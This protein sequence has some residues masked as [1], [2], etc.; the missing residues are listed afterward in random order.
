MTNTNY[1]D[2]YVDHMWRFYIRNQT[3]TLDT[4]GNASRENWTVCDSIYHK[5]SPF[6]QEVL[7]AYYAPYSTGTAQDNLTVYC[8]EHNVTT[9]QANNAIRSIRT[10]TAVERGL[11]D[12]LPPEQRKA[13]RHAPGSGKRTVVAS[14]GLIEMTGKTELT[15]KDDPTG[16]N[17]DHSEQSNQ[18]SEPT[19]N[20][21]E[22]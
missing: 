3:A 4:L 10:I 11:L 12:R 13:F 9:E 1:Y 22:E 2:G 20:H 14:S 21:A 15:G 18:H 17:A 8:E 5:S 16:N 7:S 6:R 19:P